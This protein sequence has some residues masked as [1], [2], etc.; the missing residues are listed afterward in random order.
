MGTGFLATVYCRFCETFRMVL[1][2]FADMFFVLVV[3]V[4]DI[5]RLI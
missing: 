2:G 3:A 4:N 5:W 1:L